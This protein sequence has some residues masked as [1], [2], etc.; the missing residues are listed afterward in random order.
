MSAKVV[1]K[2]KMIETTVDGIIDRINRLETTLREFD[3]SR[4][5]LIYVDEEK[6]LVSSHKTDAEYLQN[7]L[8][9]LRNQ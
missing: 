3:D 2:I 5:N 8:S 7:E 6:A 9:S 1:N 4:K